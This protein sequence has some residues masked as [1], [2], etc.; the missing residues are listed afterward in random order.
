[1]KNIDNETQRKNSS[2]ITARTA[3]FIDG[4]N[5]YS[6]AKSLGFDLDYKRLLAWMK[7]SGQLIRASYYSVLFYDENGTCPVL[8]MLDW[9]SYNG[10]AVKTK[11]GKEY[12]D[13][14]GR[15]KTKGD[16][17]IEMAVD[18]LGMSARL[19]RVILFSGDS[20]YIPL[21]EAVQRQGIHVTVVSSV[22]TSPPMC[23]DEL[24]RQADEFIDLEDLRNDCGKK[25]V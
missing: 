8:P 12:T 7:D 24:R 14:N 6:T 1:M 11:D 23:A 22:K 20:D 21:I 4:P 2:M 17:G 15:R 5:I 10:Y 25:S 3:A 16:M 13:F 18:M 19:D 9:L